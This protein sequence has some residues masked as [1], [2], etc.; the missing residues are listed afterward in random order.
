MNDSPRPISNGMKTSTVVPLAIVIGGIIVAGALYLS[1]PKRSSGG[2]AS[3]IRPVSAADHILGNPAAPVVIIEYTDFDCQYCKAFD[4]TMHQLMA[5]EG[6]TGKVAWVMREFPLT[7]IHPD[8]LALAQAAECAAQAGGN[9]KFWD[10][11]EALFKN[12]PVDPARLGPLAAAS[13]VPGTPF[14]SCYATASTTMT[15]GIMASRQNAFD[16]GATGTPYSVILKNGAVA[17]VMDGAYTYDAL[18]ALV[19]QALGQ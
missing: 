7:E 1:L 13:G 5:N 10:F 11:E 6:T 3:L 4:D 18:K 15:T 14:A 2:D 9:E 12:Q 17:A 8:A 16:I 19:D